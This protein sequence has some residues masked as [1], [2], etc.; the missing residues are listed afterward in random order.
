M[1][2]VISVTRDS[3]GAKEG[4]CRARGKHVKAGMV[5][6]AEAGGGRCL[7]RRLP[8][9]CRAL[10]SVGP[11]PRPPLH[12]PVQRRLVDAAHLVEHKQAGQQHRQR[13]DLG[14]VLARLRAAAAAAGARCSGGCTHVSDAPSDVWSKPPGRQ[15]SPAE[16]C[17]PST[18]EHASTPAPSCAHLVVG[19]DALGVQQHQR[20]AA[21]VGAAP[22]HR[23]RPHPQACGDV[24]ARGAP[25]S[26]STG[27]STM[28]GNECWRI[29][30]PA[31][32]ARNTQLSHG[33]GKRTLG[34]GAV[35]GRNLE[36]AAAAQQLVQDE[37][38]ALRDACR[39]QTAQV[40]SKAAAQVVYVYALL[41][42][43]G[44]RERRRRRALQLQGQL[45]WRA[46]PQTATTPT[47]PRVFFRACS[48]SRPSSN[49]PVA[50]SNRMS[51]RGDPAPPG[52]AP[53]PPA[54]AGGVAA[55]P[56][57]PNQLILLA[58]WLHETPRWW[59][60]RQECGSA[61]QATSL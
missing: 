44:G 33:G 43:G 32:Q 41:S 60:G 40:M 50:L 55:V 28:I 24:Q 23:R 51:S 39:V 8:A 56:R 27:S 57:R 49:F 30:Q 19:V 52:A 53:E 54:A 37:R 26:G 25:L 48:A 35:R 46:R 5:A 47:G 9:S 22:L 20:V 61:R 7:K 18:H 45:T 3:L 16:R 15:P 42:A 12:P 4:G 17:A 34:A 21:A 36:A 31:G 38:L 13:E 29:R 14:G 58:D 59:E 11:G 10:P 2:R 1:W 6:E